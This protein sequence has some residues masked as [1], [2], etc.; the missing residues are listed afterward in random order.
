MK[1][2][3]LKL[4]SDLYNYYH[5]PIE[6]KPYLYFN[7]LS[8]FYKTKYNRERE[9]HKVLLGADKKNKK[10]D[11]NYLAYLLYNIEN[12]NYKSIFDFYKVVLSEDDYGILKEQRSKLLVIEK[13][14]QIRLSKIQDENEKN[15]D[16]EKIIRGNK[17]KTILMD[18]L[19]GD[20]SRIKELDTNEDDYEITVYENYDFVLKFN[21][22]NRIFKLIRITEDYSYVVFG[23]FTKLKKIKRKEYTIKSDIKEKDSYVVKIQ[24]AVKSDD[25]DTKEFNLNNSKILEIG[26]HIKIGTEKDQHLINCYESFFYWLKTSDMIRTNKKIVTNCY[27]VFNK[28]LS[29]LPNNAT[30]QNDEVVSDI[31]D[32]VDFNDEELSSF[33]LIFE[34]DKRR[35]YDKKDIAKVRNKFKN[36]LESSYR[37][38]FV[39]SYSLISIFRQLI[40]R[41]FKL[42]GFNYLCILSNKSSTGKSTIIKICCNSLLT[43]YEFPGYGADILKMS[44]QRFTGLSFMALPL[45]IDD[46]KTITNNSTID[47]MKTSATH[48][49]GLVKK[50]PNN[51]PTYYYN[52]RP[53]VVSANRFEI[54]DPNLADRFMIVNFDNQRVKEKEFP[55]EEK[56][57]NYLLDN[58]SILSYE[59]WDNID[60]LKEILINQTIETSR[61]ENEKTILNLGNILLNGFFN[62]LGDNTCS[63]NDDNGLLIDNSRNTILTNDDIVRNT[64]FEEIE[65]L[66]KINYKINHKTQDSDSFSE[67]NFRY[68]LAGE[69][70]NENIVSAI[71]RKAAQHHIKIDYDKQTNKLKINITKTA[72][73]S[74]KFKDFKI[75]TLPSLKDYILNG[76][77]KGI[78]INNDVIKVFAFTMD[79]SNVNL[80]EEE[81]Q[82]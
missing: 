26:K 4:S 46:L 47:L 79:C 31:E 77:Y 50:Y 14:E 38:R 78:R 12:K 9:L 53:F 71:K 36:Y 33:E 3:N 64:I 6:L 45:T 21:V 82:D 70:A 44:T 10:V 1:I 18:I 68:L 30:L 16:R 67:Y 13:K 29:L 32:K 42:K 28:N 60:K 57:L 34:K 52:L 61:E 55:V 7:C 23:L 17:N 48:P 2:K 24:N 59:L 69:C 80:E 65:R 40:M 63:F 75:T 74:M 51:T 72:L 22:I 20:Y 15:K 76:K 43:G 25:E 62:I 56:L 5:K 41:D 54:K 35:I 8:S 37:A 81:D 58:M 11:I 19:E 27:G 66:T 39:T 73:E 49:A